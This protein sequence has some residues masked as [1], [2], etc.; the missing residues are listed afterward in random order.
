MMDL[1]VN[2]FAELNRVLNPN[3]CAMLRFGIKEFCTVV[4]MSCAVN[5]VLSKKLKC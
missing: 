5:C 1:C 4:I 3:K 2:E